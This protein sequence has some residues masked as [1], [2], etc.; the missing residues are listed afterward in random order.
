MTTNRTT[1]DLAR[2]FLSYCESHPQL[3][4]WQALSNWS[5]YSRI[6]GVPGKEEFTIEELEKYVYPYDTFNKKN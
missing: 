5:G 1:V 3:R 4:F 2:D 6:L